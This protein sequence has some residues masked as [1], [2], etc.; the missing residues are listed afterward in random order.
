[1]KRIHWLRVIELTIRTVRET[2]E[3]T[4]RTV[5]ACVLISVVAAAIAVIQATR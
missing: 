3:S 2:L 5:R 1:M 4:P